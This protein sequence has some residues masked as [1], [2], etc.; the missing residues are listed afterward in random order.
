MVAIRW[1]WSDVTKRFVTRCAVTMA[2]AI[3]VV[4]PSLVADAAQQ[5]AWQS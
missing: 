3:L 2:V 4:T 5:V 1:V